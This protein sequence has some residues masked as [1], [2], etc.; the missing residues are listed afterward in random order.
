MAPQ[1]EPITACDQE[2]PPVVIKLP[3]EAQRRIRE[4]QEKYAGHEPQGS[5]PGA[6]LSGHGEDDEAPH[7]PAAGSSDAAGAAAAAAKAKGKQPAGSG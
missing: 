6:V 3:E 1:A 4:A 7:A 2:H 5:V